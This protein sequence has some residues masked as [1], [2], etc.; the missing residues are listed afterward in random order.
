MIATSE[1]RRQT[2]SVTPITASTLVSKAFFMF[3]ICIDLFTNYPFTI[4][5]PLQTLLQ[6]RNRTFKE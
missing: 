1:T 4:D 2:A 3:P 6:C 5:L